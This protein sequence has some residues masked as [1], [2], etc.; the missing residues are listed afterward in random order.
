MKKIVAL[1]IAAATICGGCSDDRD[2]VC[3]EEFRMITLQVQDPDRKPVLLDS[4]FTVRA[5]NGERIAST[6]QIPG[7]Y[8]VLDDNYQPRLKRERDNFIFHGFRGGLKV[9]EETYSVSADNCH[10]TKLSGKDSVMI[11]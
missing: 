5:G 6:Q 1:T 8:T 11:Q 10:I 4:F 7:Y 2:V 9:V 3:T